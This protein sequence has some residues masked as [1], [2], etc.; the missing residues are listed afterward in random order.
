M[1]DRAEWLL[2]AL[3]E[4]AGEMQSQVLELGDAW[5][6]RRPL[7]DELS[8]LELAGRVR[9]HELITAS[10]LEQL[11]YG[12]VSTLKLHDLEWLAPDRD[13]AALDLERLMYEYLSV[14]RRTCSLLWSLGPR[15]WARRAEHPFMGS[16][17]VEEIAVALHEHDLDHMWRAKRIV[18][19][20]QATPSRAR[21]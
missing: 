19:A 1:S 5:A 6:T 9:D 10:H 12:P 20:L 3:Y 14:R 15:A 7:P 11:A 21:P 18:A 2:K 4:A 13:D 16:V 17:S 8:L